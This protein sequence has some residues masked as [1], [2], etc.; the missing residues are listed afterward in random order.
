MIQI[1]FN[2]STEL[3]AP[4]HKLYMY[5]HWMF[6]NQFC[7]LWSR[8]EIQDGHHFWK[9]FRIERRDIGV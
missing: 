2:K 7:V 9:E 3:L 5:D 4:D 1:V 6:C 8:L